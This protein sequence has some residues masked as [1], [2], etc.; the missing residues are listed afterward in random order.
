MGSNPTKYNVIWPTR[1]PTETCLE[2]WCGNTV[3]ALNIIPESVWNGLLYD[4]LYPQ[5]WARG[6]TLTGLGN[7]HW[8]DDHGYA[9]LQF[10]MTVD[11]ISAADV[12][13]ALL[14]AAAAVIAAIAALAG[15]VTWGVAAV[16]IGLA[17]VA[18]LLVL[19][20][21]IVQKVSPL[22]ASAG[23]IIIAVGAA[24]AIALAGLGVA[25]MLK[26]RGGR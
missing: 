19:L 26:S 22:A 5:V 10:T 17:A 20:E 8:I 4:S 2:T 14:A 16:V 24:A 11:P 6:G 7:A 23:L 3:N 18:G 25:G 12:V 9:A 1:I 13:A 15:V 21:P